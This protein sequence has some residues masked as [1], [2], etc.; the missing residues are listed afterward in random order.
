M[1]LRAV[2]GDCFQ[3]AAELQAA[4]P[5][6]ILCHGYVIGQEGGTATVGQPHAHA[7]V[8]R[9]IV[10]HHPSREEGYPMVT[11]I[12]KS[13]GNDIE[14]PQGMFYNVGRIEWDQVRRYTRT[15]AATHMARTQQWGP[16]EEDT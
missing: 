7:W 8:E 16:W 14:L 15:E 12:D 2:S 3:V 10:L 13:N 9:T 5:E 11:C 1:E 6:L 4:D